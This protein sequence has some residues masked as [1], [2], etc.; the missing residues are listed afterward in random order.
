MPDLATR[1][2]IDHITARIDRG[3]SRFQALDGELRATNALAQKMC[4]DTAE[5]LEFFR[6]MKG[7]FKVLNLVGRLAKPMA[8]I[9]ALGAALVG[10]WTAVKTGGG[11]R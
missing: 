8:A 11:P 10:L 6:A 9:V 3:D 2:D 7:A 4:D 1:E 5:M